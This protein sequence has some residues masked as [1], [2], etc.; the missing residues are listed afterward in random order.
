MRKSALNSTARGWQQGFARSVANALLV[1]TCGVTASLVFMSAQPAGG[2]SSSSFAWPGRNRAALSLS[3]DD[4]RPSQL[5]A[6]KVFDETGTKVTLFLTSKNIGDHA[7]AWRQA[8]QA[9]HEIANH[10]VSHPCSG[11]FDWSRDNAL[12]DFTLDRI[13]REMTDANAAI[14]RATGVRPTTFAYPCG[15]TF[16]GRGAHVASYVPVVGELFLAGRG[17]QGESANDPQ[18]VDLAQVIGC[19]MDNQDWRTLQ[20]LVDTA[21]AKGQWL[22]LGG[23]DIGSTTGPQVTRIET[24]RALLQYATADRGVW[25]DTF[26]HVADHIKRTRR[27]F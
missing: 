10:T 2:R 15:Q 7:A 12:E 3:F 27:P 21:I 9:G 4:A 1:L 6:L 26:A 18:F 24:I 17:W 25:V 22:V 8:A 23:H 16:V 14:E 13:R 20:P 19:S 5:E 11:N